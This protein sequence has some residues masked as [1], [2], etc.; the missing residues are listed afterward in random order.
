[1]SALVAPT[2][3][4]RRRRERDL[5]KALDLKPSDIW[6]LY[7]IAPSTLHGYCNNADPDRRLPSILY[8]GRSGR[9]GMRLINHEDF[10]TW[11]AKWTHAPAA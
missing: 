1:M 3:P 9:K 8:P 2:Q 4:R 5:T 6:T 11:R 7:G 10:K